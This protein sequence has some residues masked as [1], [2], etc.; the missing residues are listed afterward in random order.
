MYKLF[1]TDC[2]LRGHWNLGL[3]YRYRVHVLLA[4]GVVKDDHPC[5]TSWF[6]LE[7][8]K[9][10]F[11]DYQVMNWEQPHLMAC[12]WYLETLIEKIPQHEQV[13]RRCIDP[14][15]SGTDL[16]P[17]QPTKA[18]IASQ[19]KSRKWRAKGKTELQP[20]QRAQADGSAR[21]GKRGLPPVASE[22]LKR[23]RVDGNQAAEVDPQE[24][25][26]SH[27]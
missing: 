18:P 22:A 16:L 20:A 5:F 9:C 11:S 4:E 3:L 7:G 19:S 24:I 6:N 15:F 10:M 25:T 17:P 21:V 8:E 23:T 12:H 2:H 13:N 14:S 27:S 1:C 26:Q